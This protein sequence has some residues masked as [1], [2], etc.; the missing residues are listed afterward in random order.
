MLDFFLF[1]RILLIP[2]I[3][4]R[5]WF[6][7]F[8]SIPGITLM[9]SACQWRPS[10]TDVYIPCLRDE[11]FVARESRFF[12]NVLHWLLIKIVQTNNL[13]RIYVENTLLGHSWMHMKFSHEQTERWIRVNLFHKFVWIQYFCFIWIIM[14][15]PSGLPIF[16]GRCPS[17]HELVFLSLYHDNQVTRLPFRYL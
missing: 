13:P 9:S 1:K 5:R 11:C 16:I 7:S 2:I 14:I 3:L 12:A 4:S 10:T 17:R 15:S 6:T 8:R